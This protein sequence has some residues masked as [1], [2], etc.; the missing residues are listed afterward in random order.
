MTGVQTC[1]LPICAGKSTLLH[2]LAGLLRP[3]QGEI[4]ADGHPVSR[5]VS[6]HRDLWRRKVGIIFQQPHLLPD[7]TTLENVFLPLIPLKMSVKDIRRLGFSALERMG[8][9]HLSGE[10][11]LRLSGGE[12]QRVAIARAIIMKPEIIIADE[13]T[14]HQDSENTNLV[15]EAFQNFK[16]EQAVVIV[17]VHESGIPDFTLF[18]RRFHLENGILREPA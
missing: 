12:R 9:R 18:D 5:W 1:A 14:S 11:A 8:V 17:S 6:F 7:L 16:D 2:I 3:T 4:A 13:P 10:K 15:L